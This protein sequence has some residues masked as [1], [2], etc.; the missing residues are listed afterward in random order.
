MMR[1]RHL[2]P[3]LFVASLVLL[4]ILG[5]F[6]PRALILLAFVVGAYLITAVFFSLDAARR[7]GW[8][9]LYSLPLSFLI[10]HLSYGCGTY[11]GALGVLV[12]NLQY[13]GTYS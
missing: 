2:I 4:P 12:S 8:R 5:L 11:V 3:A 7:Y 13:K 1:L 6:Q 9:Y 10:I